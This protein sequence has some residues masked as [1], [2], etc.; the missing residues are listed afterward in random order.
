MPDDAGYIHGLRTD[1]TYNVYLSTVT[2]TTDDQRRWIDAYRQREAEGREAYYV[3]ERRR[4]ESR[5]GVVRLYGITADRF[6]WGSWILDANKPPKA[7]LESAV[8][9][10]DIGFGHLGLTLANI[11]VRKGNARSL[12]LYRRFGVT[13]AGEDEEKI[14]FTYSR[15]RFLVDRPRHM[16]ALSETSG[17]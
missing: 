11:D 15:E 7:A 10:Y 8:L 5:C 4:D 14:L 1:P 6:T 12:A 3:I 2:G 16:Q 17:S 13:E 9:V